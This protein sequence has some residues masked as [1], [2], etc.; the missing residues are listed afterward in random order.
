MYET[1]G[2]SQSQHIKTDVCVCENTSPLYNVGGNTV[3]L[4][5][6]HLLMLSTAKNTASKQNKKTTT[7]AFL[8]MKGFF[9]PRDSII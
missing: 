1:T 9:F 2:Q 7:N 3:K 8:Y 5:H 4:M 6:I